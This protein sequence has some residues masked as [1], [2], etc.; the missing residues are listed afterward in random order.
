MIGPTLGG[1]LTDTYSWRWMFFINI[2]VGVATLAAVVA[3]L[4]DPPWAKQ[5]ARRRST[6]VGL[7]L[8]TLGAGLP[9]GHA[10]PRRGRRLV[11]LALHP[12]QLGLLAVIGILGAIGWLLVARK[13]VVN[14]RVFLDRN[15]AIGSLM[16]GMMGCVLYSSAV[17]I[18]QFAPAG[19]G[20]HR[21]P[22]RADP[23]AGGLVLIVLIPIVGWLMGASRCSTVIA[24]GFT[25]MG[26]A[27]LYS[28]HLV[29]DIDFFTPGDDAR[30]PDGGAGVPVRADQ[31]RRLRHPAAR[32]E[33]RRGGAVL[34]G[35]QRVRLDR[36]LA[37]PPRR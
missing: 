9:A 13:P 22:G 29:P 19:A 11:R 6:M 37:S 10:R 16:I 27:M 20:L 35:A 25:L 5:G 30:L 14:L 23:V 8:I 33:R 7:A 31:H 2:P 4:E 28:S 12:R 26:F 34:H 15:F 1:C 24:I 21:D 18:P 36:H 32:A 17:V 3:V